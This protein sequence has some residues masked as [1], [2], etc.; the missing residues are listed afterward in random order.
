[1]TIMAAAKIL[2]EMLNQTTFEELA[3]EWDLENSNSGSVR[4]KI[5]QAA[6]MALENE[7][8][9]DTIDG[10]QPLRRAMV[11]MAMR[12]PK[13]IKS[14]HNDIWVKL[15][16]GLRFDGYEIVEEQIESLED[17]LFGEPIFR[18]KLSLKKMLPD[19]IPELN[20]REAESELVSLLKKH[21][22][23]VPLGHL[24]QAFKNFSSGHWAAANGAMR[25]FYEGYLDEVANRIGY[26]GKDDAYKRRKYLAECS[27]P[28]LL[29][30]YNEPIYVQNLM[31][32]MH[33]Q[34]SHPGLSEEDDCTFRLQITLIRAR[35]FIRRFD[36]R[37]NGTQP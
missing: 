8:L 15:K 11:D 32:R 29:E 21:K 10:R 6:R 33:P 37:L 16:T 34:G 9:V 14:Q 23:E 35:L 31:K 26:V 28:F 19:D 20:F 13:R 12:A 3:V 22:F 4:L 25:A 1:M 24:D 2:T 5:T 36:Q 30:K 7:H 18:T 27:P 17:N